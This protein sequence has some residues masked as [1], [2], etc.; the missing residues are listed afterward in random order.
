MQCKWH[1]C[2]N[3]SRPRSPFCSET[4][5]KRHARRSGTNVPVEVGQEQSGTQV[6]QIIKDVSDN[7]GECGFVETPDGIKDI[8]R[9]GPISVTDR[10]APTPTPDIFETDQRILE[11]TEIHTITG[12]MM[13]DD[14]E[15]LKAFIVCE[16]DN[17]A[18]YAPFDELGNMSAFVKRA[19]YLVG[20]LIPELKSLKEEVDRH[21]KVAV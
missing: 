17:M 13:S 19:Y 15:R 11:D 9:T 16:V 21:E 5:K 2:S 1:K 20:D 12:G 18:A 4:C 6:G 3:E 14:I 8:H 10:H 7:G